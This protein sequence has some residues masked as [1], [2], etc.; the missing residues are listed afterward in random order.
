MVGENNAEKEKKKSSK[1]EFNSDSLWT[2]RGIE[3]VYFLREAQVNFWSILGGIAVAR[4][5]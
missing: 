2:Q 4:A 3:D 1:K 5:T